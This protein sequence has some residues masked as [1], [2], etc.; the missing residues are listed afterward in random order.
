MNDLLGASTPGIGVPFLLA[1]KSAVFLAVRLA[2][3]EFVFILIAF[4]VI[5]PFSSFGDAA[6]RGSLFSSLIVYVLGLLITIKVA[7]SFLA[8]LYWLREYYEIKPHEVIYRRGIIGKKEVIFSCKNVQ[9]I[10]VHQSVWGRIF[11]FGTISLYNPVLR[12]RFHLRDIS[13]PNEHCQLIER[14]VTGIEQQDQAVS[15]PMREHAS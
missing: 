13:E 1:R 12:E 9:E 2:V 5:T 15:V 7:V 3:I 8:C 14:L 4:L 11:N 6:A 10:E